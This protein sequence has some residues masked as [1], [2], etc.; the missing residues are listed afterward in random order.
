MLRSIMNEDVADRRLIDLSRYSLSQL[1]AGA[2]KSALD[3]ALDRIL[4]SENDEAYSS[5]Q[6]II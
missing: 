6:A 5:F 1:Q 4:A 2:R 3:T